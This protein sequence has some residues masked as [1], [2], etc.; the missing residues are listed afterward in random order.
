MIFQRGSAIRS[1]RKRFQDRRKREEKHRINSR[2]RVPEVRLI[3]SEG[4]M[5]GLMSSYEALKAAREKGLDLVEISP[6]STP[7]IC[8][9]MDY[10][11]WKFDNKKKERQS[12]KNQS[13]ILIKEIQ[14]RPRTGEGDI[15]IKLDKA[16]GF[17]SQGHKVKVN[18]RFHGRE[19]A[20][21]E[22]GF[23][24]L[25][26][27]EKRL[28]DVA[29]IEMPAK[30]ERRTLFTIF[31][32][33]ITKPSKKISLVQPRSQPVLETGRIRKKPEEDEKSPEQSQT[34]VKSDK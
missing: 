17:L 7:P 30:M 24:I 19:M 5:M 32:P 16:K 10:G 3:G 21:K 8:K 11:K 31:A 22:L 2:I 20:H 13:K 9:I 18:L 28:S 15:N 27:V 29:S 6:N 12:K 26:N 4:N 1:F 33:G 23:K 25:K 14:L 34:A